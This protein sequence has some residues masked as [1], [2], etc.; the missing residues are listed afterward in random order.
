MPSESEFEAKNDSSP[1]TTEK[2]VERDDKETLFESLRNIG[3]NNISTLVNRLGLYPPEVAVLEDGK[4]TEA[5]TIE[6]K[7]IREQQVLGN[8]NKLLRLMQLDDGPETVDLLIK[9]GLQ[10]RN[11]LAEISKLTIASAPH[12]RWYGAYKDAPTRPDFRG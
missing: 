9:I 2:E 11:M 3:I 12:E 7:K 10:G 8:A 1:E 4:K 5:R 6:N